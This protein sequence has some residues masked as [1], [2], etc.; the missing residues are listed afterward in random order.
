MD[1]TWRNRP[2]HLGAVLLIF[3]ALSGCASSEPQA[4]LGQETIEIGPA[5]LEAGEKLAVVATTNILGDV[6]SQVGG[7]QIDLFTLMR[8]GVDP[9]S[10]VPTPA[11]T[12]AVHD[13]HVVLANG[14][15]LEGFLDGMLADSGGEAAIVH[16][17]EGIQSR[18][19]TSGHQEDDHGNE[20]IDPHVWFDVQNVIHWVEIIESVLSTMDPAHA[21]VYAGNANSYR[22]ELEELDNWIVEQVATIPEAHRKLVTSHPSFGYFA[23]RY[24]LEQVG[25]VYPVSPSSEPS[26]QDIAILQ[27]AIREF[28]V[29]AVFAESTVNPKLA[30]Q[31]SEDTGI[32][33]VPLY[34]GS[35]G[36]PGSGVESYV[37]LMRYDVGAIVRALT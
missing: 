5:H 15:G 7:D 2:A 32:R 17:S 10:Y 36:G 29:P 35:L 27:D 31:V 6:V 8:T 26:A 18:E 13:A 12:A 14:L 25:A 19:A 37:E 28:D 21:E 33:L 9:H 22:Q 23:E 1:S 30:Q 11:D 24:G 3:V 4:G 34:T 16:V 20:E